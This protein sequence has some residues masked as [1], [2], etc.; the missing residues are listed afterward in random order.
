MK[1]VIKRL[2]CKPKPVMVNDK[3]DVVKPIKKRVSIKVGKFKETAPGCLTA[4]VSVDVKPIK[5]KNTRSK[6]KG[7]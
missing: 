1:K 7:K 5:K 3:I 6:K 2:F 4:D